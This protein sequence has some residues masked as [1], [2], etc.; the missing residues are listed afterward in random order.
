MKAMGALFLIQNSRLVL[1]Y[2]LNAIDDEFLRN[3]L[4]LSMCSDKTT[5]VIV[6]ADNENVPVVWMNLMQMLLVKVFYSSA[7]NPS[8]R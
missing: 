3:G 4:T 1:G 6:R 2:E 8:S 5:V 7:G